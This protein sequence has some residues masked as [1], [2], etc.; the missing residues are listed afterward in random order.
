MA[1]STIIGIDLS[2]PANHKDTAL[3]ILN[4]KKQLEL[5]S[6]L[7]DLEI[8]E[9]VG[10]F[11][12]PSIFIDA[13]LSYSD[14]G[15]NRKSDT[16]LRT[17]LN[18]RGFNRIAVMAPTFNR[19]IYLTARG[20][21]LSRLLSRIKDSKV[22]ETHPGAYLALSGY[23]YELIQQLKKDSSAIKTLTDAIRLKGYQFHDLPKSDHEL[24]SLACA[25]AGQAYL[26]GNQNWLWPCDGIDGFDYIA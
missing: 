4:E 10:Q 2:G 12:W 14:T 16:D 22:V 19:M 25:L 6:G 9:L 17:L 11:E 18:S 13:P 24:M 15:G 7:N 23:N 8:Y 5:H 1:K 26:S 20:I 21:R 3:A